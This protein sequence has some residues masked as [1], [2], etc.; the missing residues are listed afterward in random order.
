MADQAAAGA[1]A[2]SAA[3]YLAALTDD[4]GAFDASAENLARLC[5]FLRAA[6]ALEAV[7][8]AVAAEA[9]AYL[10][11]RVAPALAGLA[12][13]LPVDEDQEEEEEE[14]QQKLAAAAPRPCE[15]AESLEQKR[16]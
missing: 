10:R 16:Y 1:D 14:E 13:V 15:R 8:G 11:G 5:T 2:R 12:A 9:R 4:D 6:E 7:V 3:L